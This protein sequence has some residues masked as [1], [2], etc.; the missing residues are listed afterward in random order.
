MLIVYAH[1]LL[2]G[3]DRITR[4]W[5]CN[6]FSGDGFRT[7]KAKK[8]KKEVKVVNNGQVQTTTPN[9]DPFDSSAI[10]TCPI[11]GCVKVFQSYGKL[12]WHIEYGKCDYKTERE[13]LLNKAKVM[14]AEKLFDDNN[15]N[16]QVNVKSGV[17]D[18]EVQS[19]NKSPQ[20]WAL[21]SK[22]K[23]TRFTK[24]QKEFLDE[25]FEKGEKTG[26]KYDPLQVSLA[27]RIAKDIEGKRIFSIEEF[28][29]AEQI[30]GYFSRR[31]S[32]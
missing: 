15:S 19:T 8:E 32:K 9:D 10:F 26:K 3:H 2:I 13:T 20:G 28:L 30:K 1:Y 24:K 5:L 23:T 16:L 18:E 12:T 22:K 14:Y 7:V 6:T 21:R 17:S 25:K 31:S 29:S 27:M 4:N 11:E